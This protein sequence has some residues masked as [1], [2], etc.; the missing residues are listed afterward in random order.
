[1]QH[2]PRRPPHSVHVIV[3]FDGDKHK[4]LTWLVMNM[5]DSC[6][7]TESNLSAVDENGYWRWRMSLNPKD[8]RVLFERAEDVTI[9]Q[10]AWGSSWPVH[11]QNPH[12]TLRASHGMQSDCIQ[13]MW[14]WVRKFLIG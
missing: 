1:M 4:V 12:G 11:M 10:L 2:K 8:R 7:L 9:F 6:T 5:A 3:P 13:I 14:D